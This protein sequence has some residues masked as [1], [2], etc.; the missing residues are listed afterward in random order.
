ME[1]TKRGL[2][3]LL[4]LVLFNICAAQSISIIDFVKVTDGYS[5]EAAFFYAN[6]WAAFRAQAKVNGWIEDYQL[7]QVDH[8][9]WDLILITDFTDSTQHKAIEQHFAAWS[10][11]HPLA[12]LNENKPETFRNNVQSVTAA[13]N[14][15]PPAKPA[16]ALAP[17]SSANHRAFDF[18]IGS[19]TVTNPE[20][21]RAGHNEIIAI[22]GGCA[23]QENWTSADGSYKG[24][25]YNFYDALSNRWHQSWIDNQGGVLQLSGGLKGDHM[26]LTSEPT[27]NQN[28]QVQ[29]DRITWIPGSDGSVQQ[30]WERSTD[31]GQHWQKVFHGIYRK[32]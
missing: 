24:T 1:Y 4:F 25:S 23:L 21:K 16:P 9:D 13:H 2:T 32:Q 3:L 22:Q 8:A 26:V 14:A 5:R 15:L 31:D 30:T 10:V 19:W 12:L 18:W 28:G 6:N 20:G 17:C 7:L 29:T 27:R 11:A